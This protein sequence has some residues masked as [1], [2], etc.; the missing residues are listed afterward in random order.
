MN[1]ESA[2][3][4]IR[5]ELATLQKDYAAAKVH[6]QRVDE[7]L[8]FV[9]EPIE[10]QLFEANSDSIISSPRQFWYGLELQAMQT[11]YSEI[12]EMVRHLRPQ[13]GDLWVDLGAGYGRIGILL[14]FLHP[15]VRFRG[16]EYVLD[17]VLEGQRIFKQWNLADV[18]LR[19]ADLA[20]DD[21]VVEPAEVYFLYDFGSR[22][23]I[24]KVLHKLG[25]VARHKKIKVIARG[26]GVRSWIL[27]DFPWLYDVEPPEHFSTWSLFKS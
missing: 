11:P 20:T 25:V 8:G 21:F 4:A 16:Y 5:V 15:G 9:C 7:L 19:Q 10:D 3:Q 1:Q 18:E 27:M 23:D 6:A 26:R 12:L 24:Y 22:D 2:A 14:G 17:R 13:S